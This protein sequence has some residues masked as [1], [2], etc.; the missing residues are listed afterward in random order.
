MQK[1]FDRPVKVITGVLLVCIVFIG[2]L[3]LNHDIGIP[4]SQFESDIRSSQRIDSDWIVDGN[5]SDTIAAFISYPRDMTNHTFS[6]YVNRPGLSFGYFFRGGGSLLGAEDGIAECTVEGYKERAFISMNKQ[7]VER[8]EID[9]G[10]SIRVVDIDSGKPFSIV[11]PVNAGNIAFY[12]V[13]GNI[14]DFSEQQL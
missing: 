2:F 8:L 11:L 9:D 12:D 4:K 10:N 7:Q 1:R 13:N 14:V 3:Y 5:V 6:V